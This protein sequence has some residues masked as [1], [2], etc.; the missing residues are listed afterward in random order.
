MRPRGLPGVG[1]LFGVTT[2]GPIAQ[3]VRPGD[4][5]MRDGA[6][7][8]RSVETAVICGAGRRPIPAC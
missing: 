8:T 5:A 3:I 4:R 1:P 2:P 6:P 7:L